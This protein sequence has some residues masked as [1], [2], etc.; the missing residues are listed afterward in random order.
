MTSPQ[1]RLRERM[2]AR[3]DSIEIVR[4]ESVQELSE[5][6]ADWEHLQ[7]RYGEAAPD[8]APDLFAA[9]LPVLGSGAR[10][11]VALFRDAEG[12]RA[13]LV[14]R[15]VRRAVACRFGYYRVRT[16][17][18]HC[19]EVPY[20]GLVTDRSPGA[21]RAVLSY[22]EDLLRRRAVEHLVLE[23]LPR[24]HELFESLARLAVVAR[25]E[26]H[27]RLDLVPGSF[28]ETLRQ[29][30]KKHRYNMRRADRMLVEHFGGAVSLRLFAR[31]GELDAFFGGA[32]Q[33]VSGSYQAR[34]GVGLA[35]NPRWRTILGNLA[36]RGRLRAFWL[37][38]NGTPIAFQAGAVW[39]EM[40][41]LL[42][43]SYL[44]AFAHLSPGTVLLVR[45]LRDL[46]DLG[47]RAVDY[48]FGDADYKRIY[49]SRS[50]DEQT[51]RLY[52]PGPRATFARGLDAS[53]LRASALG[54]RT[55]ERL[56]ILP[57]LKRRWRR[58]PPASDA[59]AG[60]DS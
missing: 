37:E 42:A 45:V 44:P 55:I 49:G 39:N 2:P 51:L 40:Y 58:A 22:V 14:G 48:G 21:G 23:H 19:L 17:R 24:R 46:C 32:S 35:D 33:V 16:P 9:T 5:L 27:W 10:P 25:S 54:A 28:E 1:A 6:R 31:A 52:G 50:W 4:A 20:G 43:T 53:L 26:M 57:W 34:L 13:L 11:H 18:L 36:E 41:L 30:G 12:P 38:A 29:F 15:T 7:Q 8:A 47:C 60:A 56:G 3:G 59:R